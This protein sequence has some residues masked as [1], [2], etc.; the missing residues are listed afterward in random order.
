MASHR[1]SV[2]AARRATWCLVSVLLVGGCLRMV[3]RYPP[4]WRS[5]RAEG[6][7]AI[8]GT[9]EN[10]GEDSKGRSGEA[11]FQ[12]LVAV[13]DHEK[14]RRSGDREPGAVVIS[15]P[16]P[17]VLEVRTRSLSQRFLA[18]NWEF[19]CSDGVLE[20]A[21]TGGS[22]GNV[23]GWYGSS[24]VRVAKDEDGWLVVSHDDSGFALLGWAIPIYMTGVTWNRFKPVTDRPARE[25][26]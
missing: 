8:V 2:R 10:L 21:R 3:E 15:V 13:Y 18:R 1:V 26:N 19:A 4:T 5:L 14:S 12:L 17:G 22:G 6:C 20:F 9:Y 11:L 24:V 7:N 16:A 23:G 25:K